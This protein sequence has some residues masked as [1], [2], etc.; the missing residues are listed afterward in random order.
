MTTP[1]GPAP[2][3]TGRQARRQARADRTGTPKP[4]ITKTRV[5]GGFNPSIHPSVSINVTKTSPTGPTGA[6]APSTATTGAT[7]GGD[8]MSNEDIRAWCEDVRKKARNRAVERAMD[9]EQLEAVLRRIPTAEGSV[10]GARMRARRVS[11]HAKVIARAEQRIAKAA[12]ALYA[13]FER[14]FDANLRK[15]GKARPP[16]PNRFRF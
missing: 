16:Q 6:A 11:R 10:A 12:A 2:R 13:Q 3:T 5:G 15:V 14:E 4:T 7:P 9:A 8:F 1:T